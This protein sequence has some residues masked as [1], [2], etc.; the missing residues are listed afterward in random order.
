MLTP[1]RNSTRIPTE[2]D[3]TSML[4][5]IIISSS[6][7]SSIK[8]GWSRTVMVDTCRSCGGIRPREDLP[9]FILQVFVCSFSAALLACFILAWNDYIHLS[10]KA[11]LHT[12]APIKTRPSLSLSLS[13]SLAL[14]LALA[15]SLSL[16]VCLSLPLCLS[17]SLSLINSI[18]SDKKV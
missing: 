6:S 18:H 13:L 3:A 12:R 14:A 5:I 10:K 8:V 4:N 7:S 1:I 17:L 2:S 11:R 15:L 16:S 9:S